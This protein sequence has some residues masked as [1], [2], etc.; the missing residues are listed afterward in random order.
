MKFSNAIIMVSFEEAFSFT[1]AFVVEMSLKSILWILLLARPVE[2]H[3][4]RRNNYCEIY[5]QIQLGQL[6]RRD[7]LKGLNISIAILPH[8]LDKEEGKLVQNYIGIQ[9]FDEVAR[10][11]QFSYQNNFQVFDYA[12][13]NETYTDVLLYMFNHTDVAVDWW[14]REI[15][16]VSIGITGPTG[17]YDASTV[18]IGKDDSIT[19]RKVD[20][21]SVFTPFKYDVWIMIVFTVLMSGFIYHFI[22]YILHHGRHE[23]RIGD[24]IYKSVMAF[25]GNPD[26][27]PC[28]GPSRA[29]LVSMTLLSIVIV[30]AYT[31]NLASF[32][33]SDTTLV[34]KDFQDV[35]N[36]KYRVCVVKAMP[37]IVE[38]KKK[39]ENGLYVDKVDEL[40]VYQGLANKECEVA[41]M[42]L[43]S[44]RSV[45]TKTEYNPDCNIKIMG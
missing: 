18:I 43:E 10:R 24:N 19:S 16:R 38:I 12:T 34:I 21:F 14:V 11:A 40:G 17:W 39:Y 15:E 33:I 1:Q 13:G 22:D 3:I 29:I 28:F 44:H 4:D 30:A 25:S 7:A 41:L 26:S 35:I 9:I 45:V 27:S 23:D 42:A 5:N 32:L 20:L 8:A 6:E 31:A 36:N 37:D 2:S